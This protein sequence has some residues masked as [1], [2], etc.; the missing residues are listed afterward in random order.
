MERVR[1]C[2]GLVSDT[3]DVQLTGRCFQYHGVTGLLH[4]MVPLLSVNFCSFG[5]VPL[6]I[7]NA[8]VFR[9]RH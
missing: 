9:I 8:V 5:M 3:T 7:V 2:E 1:G 4:Q 6:G